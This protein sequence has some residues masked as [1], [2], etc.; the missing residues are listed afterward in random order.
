[1]TE[2]SEPKKV[3][4]LMRRAPY[5]TFYIFEGLQTMLVMGAYELDISLAFADDGV[6]AVTD[7]QD[8]SA[9]Q[10]KPLARTFRALP[11][12]DIDQIYIHKDS[13]EERGL[14]LDDLVVEPEVLTSEELAQVIANQDVVLP[15]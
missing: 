13:L 15:F 9:L 4:V 5:G 11:D 7:G 8:P 6:Y 10:M 12:F 2:N 1:M 3:M 14:T